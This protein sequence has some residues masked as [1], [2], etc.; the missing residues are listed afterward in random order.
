[1]SNIH[2]PIRNT[3]WAKRAGL[4]DLARATIK[5][6]MANIACNIRRLIYHETQ[7]VRCA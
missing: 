4:I 5:I 7:R 1:M 2:S 6:A 3:A